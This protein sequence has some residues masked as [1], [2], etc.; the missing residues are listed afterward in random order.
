MTALTS[1]RRPRARMSSVFSSRLALGSTLCSLLLVLATGCSKGGYDGPL[2]CLTLAETAAGQMTTSPVGPI[3][4]ARWAELRHADGTTIPINLESGFNG[5]YT[6]AGRVFDKCDP[7][8]VYYV[9]RLA[10]TDRA[11]ALVATAK[12]VGATGTTYL[13]S[14]PN[15]S[16]QTVSTTGT[17]ALSLQAAAGAAPKLDSLSAGGV[18]SVAQGVS[19]A[20]SAQSTAAPDDCGIK[21]SRFWLTQKLAPGTG[22]NSVPGSTS[23][24]ISGASG[25]AP[26]R[27]TPS[28]TEGAYVVEGLITTK[29]GRSL[30]VFRKNNS[31]ATYWLGADLN[32]SNIPIVSVNVTADP[33]ADRNGPR[34][35]ALEPA[36]ATVSRCDV[37]A[38]ALRLADDKPL[39]QTQEITL[40]IRGPGG[41]TLPLKLTGTDVLTGSLIVPNDAPAGVWYAYPLKFTDDIG[42]L[43][44]V[45]FSGGTITLTIPGAMM[46]VTLPAASFTVRGFASVDLGGGVPVDLASPAFDLAQSFPTEPLSFSFMQNP[47]TPG[48]APIITVN[49]RQGDRLP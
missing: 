18:T 5:M 14:Y 42:N 46:P 39:T 43:T 48:T 19:L 31:D 8:G 27:I 1:T 2:K 11:G 24:V 28:I 29:S 9:D 32:I 49:W 16:T 7:P 47:I 25:N 37:V 6:G 15:G 23:A 41:E 22:E 35:T 30:R 34:L 40:Q 36:A 3:P 21:E 45:S 10:V 17:N 20:L 13:V 26:L 12:H 4:T 33:M 44:S 38:F